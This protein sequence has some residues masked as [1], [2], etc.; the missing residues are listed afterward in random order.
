M[1]LAVD[2]R[3]DPAWVEGYRRIADRVF[4]VPFPG[5]PSRLYA[6][7]R[8]QCSGRWILQL[9]ADEVP[10][11]GLADEIEAALTREDEITHCWIPRRWLYPDRDH[12]LAQHPW[13][14]DYSLRLMRNDP[15]LVRFPA[16]LHLP[17]EVEGPALY[18]RE[19][20]YHADLLLATLPERETKVEIYE[21]VRPGYS[22]IE[23]RP[24][25]EAFY[26]P[27]RRSGL[28]TLPVPAGDSPAVCE[29]LSESFPV[30]LDQRPGTARPAQPGRGDADSTSAAPCPPRPTAPVCAWSKTTFG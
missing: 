7:L 13:R 16:L 22:V 4:R 1:V 26:L 8:A 6:W 12:W 28:R 25:N 30:G 24:F 5:R 14:P 20:L 23:G 19:P 11:P 21:S 3:V 2:D 18:L 9:D 15:A 29:F 17:I 27:E 10:A